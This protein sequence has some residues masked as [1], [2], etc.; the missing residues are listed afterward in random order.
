MK[1]N[2]VGTI[3]FQI[4]QLIGVSN[5]CMDLL[6]RMLELSLSQRITPEEALDHPFFSDY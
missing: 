3:N 2:K 6:T 1:N 5:D 4:P